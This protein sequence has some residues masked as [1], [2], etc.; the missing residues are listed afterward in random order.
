MLIKVYFSNL[1]E[2]SIKNLEVIGNDKQ[3]MVYKKL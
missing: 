1:K 3:K 2:V